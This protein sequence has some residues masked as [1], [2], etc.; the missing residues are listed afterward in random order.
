M[1]SMRM[2]DCVAAG[3]SARSVARWDPA[4]CALKSSSGGALDPPWRSQL[5]VEERRGLF[6]GC[7]WL[8]GQGIA[9]AMFFDLEAQEFVNSL[10]RVGVGRMDFDLSAELGAF[11]GVRNLLLKRLHGLHPRRVSRVNEHWYGKIAVAE[12]ACD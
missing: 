1:R 2:P 7:G 9:R 6:Q 8:D 11:G 10:D 3:G 5:R 12:H 4:S